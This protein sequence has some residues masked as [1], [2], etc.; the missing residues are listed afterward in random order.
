MLQSAKALA[1]EG[2]AVHWLH[3]RSKRPRGNDWSDKPRATPD[4]LEATYRDGFNVGI[5]LG[6]PSHVHGLYLHC[7]DLDVRDDRQVED[8]YAAFDEIL[9]G[10]DTNYP[11]VRSGSGGKSRHV[12]F[13]TD[14]PLR[15]KKLAHS[16]KKWT[17]AKGKEHWA[18]EIELF[19]TGKQ[20]AAPPSIHPDTGKPYVW[21]RE[22]D[23]D[24]VR[25]GY[26]PIVDSDVI[27]E[28]Q[29]VSDESDTERSSTHDGEDSSLSLSEL[30]SR[31]RL[32]IELDQAEDYLNDLPEEWCDD[33]DMWVK[34]GMALHHEFK[35]SKDALELWDEWSS[36]SSKYEEDACEHRWRSFGKNKKLRP[37]RFATIIQA[38]ALADLKDYDPAN[39]DA[40]ED[41]EDHDPNAWL[42]KLALDENGKVKSTVDN[43]VIIFA[44]DVRFKGVF[45][46]NLFSG[47]NVIRKVPG[48]KKARREK[49]QPNFWQ[50]SSDQFKLIGERMKR[51]GRPLEDTHEDEMRMLL[52]APPKR[53]GYGVQVSD[54]DMRAV[55]NVICTRNTFHPVQEYLEALEWDGKP[56][57]DRVFI[58]YLGC[59]DDAYHR[60]CSKL[61]FLAGVAR[62][63][64]PGHKFDY[65]PII[66]GPQGIRKSEF[67]KVVALREWF[68]ELNV[69]FDDTKAVVEALGGA[70]IA[71]IPELNSFSRAEIG[72]I[73][74]FFSKGEE[75]VREAYGRKAKRFERQSVY[76][77]T[78]NDREYLRDPT[79]NRRFWPI[80]TRLDG[81]HIDTEKLEKMIGRIW[82]EALALYKEMASD[83]P[84]GKL[85]LY[86]KGSD[87][88]SMAHA[89]QESRRVETQTDGW[90]GILRDWA[91]TRVPQSVIDGKGEE[92]Q[93]HDGD[94]P[95]VK[96]EMIC[97]L[98][99][100]LEVLGGTKKDYGQGNAIKVREAIKATGEWEEIGLRYMPVYNRQRVWKRVKARRRSLEDLLG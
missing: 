88:K 59:P 77:G 63:Y 53:G 93:N 6:E 18:W 98:Q 33:H 90:A 26:G 21:K 8:A 27:G 36:N 15:S 76:V 87:A 2:V 44:N 1:E 95:L 19:G 7:F 97:G 83:Y 56:R 29:A 62:I 22:I 52:V 81:K 57:L 23:F 48:I 96:R 39:S 75:K 79:G 91:N 84:L 78:T 43:L 35:G 46:K 65:V 92:F 73:K 60:Q 89:L 94:D 54:R 13:F 42:S 70:W 34:V 67:V 55:L 16:K 71:E 74:A 10:W 38:S 30:N 32:G 31:K 11:W 28:W 17:D 47:E 4:K 45:A 99:V 41:D 25:K 37:V 51:D 82:A 3:E 100:W 50:L 64:Q 12:Y 66:E 5:R 85:P 14:K 58:D 80:Q 69:D 49:D 24:Q 61:F 20:V 72:S 9:P 86:L 40:D 68:T